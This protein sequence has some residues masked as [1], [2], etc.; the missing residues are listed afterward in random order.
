VISRVPERAEKSSGSRKT[1]TPLRKA[2]QN[3]VFRF[4]GRE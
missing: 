3:K 4:R 1:N 2:E